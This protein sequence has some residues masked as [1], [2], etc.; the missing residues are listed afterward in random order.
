[1]IENDYLE[2]AE[3]DR[4]EL[5]KH[6][7]NYMADDTPIEPSDIPKLMEIAQKLQAEDTSLNIYE[8]YKHPEARAKLFSQIAEAYYM[9]LN[10]TPTQAQRLAF[11]DY[12]EQQYKTILKKMIASTDKQALGE[13]LDL[14]ELPEETEKQFI[15]DMAVS[16]IL[17]K[18]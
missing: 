1:M 11:C 7:L 15:R 8:L 6:R 12:L 17:A 10:A 9:A 13:L 3:K 18:D 4:L 16:G 14:L 2:Q 5:E